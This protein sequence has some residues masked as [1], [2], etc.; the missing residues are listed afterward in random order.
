M[1]TMT[2]IYCSASMPTLPEWVY[3][4]LS[5][6]GCIQVEYEGMTLRMAGKYIVDQFGRLYSSK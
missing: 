4:Q 6:P 5:I 3:D 1:T 2:N